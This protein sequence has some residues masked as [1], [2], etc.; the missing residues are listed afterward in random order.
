MSPRTGVPD[1]SERDLL[2]EAQEDYL[3]QVLLLGGDE[4]AVATQALADR[5]GVRPASVTGMIRR[6][7]ELGFLEHQPYSLKARLT[8]TAMA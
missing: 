3:K 8:F 7:A 1:I 2:S 6:L 4:R 5:L